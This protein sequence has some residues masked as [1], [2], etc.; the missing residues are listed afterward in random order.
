M[1]YSVKSAFVL[2][3]H[4]LVLERICAL[5]LRDILQQN[6]TAGHGTCSLVLGDVEDLAARD[7]RAWS[8]AAWPRCG[9]DFDDNGIRV[10]RLD[11]WV[12]RGRSRRKPCG[13]TAL[14]GRPKW[15][16]EHDGVMDVDADSRWTHF[17]A[18]VKS[19][20]GR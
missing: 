7:G 8:G 5:H 16:A 17:G 9:K 1:V 2:E 4:H 13:I 15:I 11:V 20:Q 6:F 12:G 18:E 19:Y 14:A 10:H 3:Y